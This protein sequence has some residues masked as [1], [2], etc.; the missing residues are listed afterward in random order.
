[1]TRE[2]RARRARTLP[3][4]RDMGFPMLQRER[5]RRWQTGATIIT[6]PE[7]SSRWRSA[8]A[9]K[10]ASTASH[11]SPRTSRQGTQVTHPGPRQRRTPNGEAALLLGRRLSDDSCGDARSRDGR[12][13]LRPLLIRQLYVTAA[14]GSTRLRVAARRGRKAS[15]TALLAL[16]CLGDGRG[17]GGGFDNGGHGWAQPSVRRRLGARAGGPSAG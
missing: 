4:H 15:P 16:H 2:N 5:E 14:K 7:D 8:R 6:E 9:R 13:M 10:I 12:E 17:G 1:M 11:K 3:F